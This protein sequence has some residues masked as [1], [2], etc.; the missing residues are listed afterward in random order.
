MTPDTIARF[1][2]I[3]S[4]ISPDRPVGKLLNMGQLLTL[5]DAYSL[6]G[7][8]DRSDTLNQ[9]KGSVE[10]CNQELVSQRDKAISELRD[11]QEWTE[12]VALMMAKKVAEFNG[13]KAR[14]EAEDLGF[15]SASA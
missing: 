13:T 7:V 8:I 14:Q 12:A 3:A 11:M 10:L 15:G 2:T 5:L 9:L 1:K 6:V 4:N